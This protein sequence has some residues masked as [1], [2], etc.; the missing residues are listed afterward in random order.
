MSKN[1]GGV[2][3]GNC[4]TFPD[5]VIEM[6]SPVPPSDEAWEKHVAIS[7]LLDIPLKCPHCKEIL[8]NNIKPPRK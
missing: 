6:F 8:T 3:A 4:L 5:E 1:V 2:A 7:E